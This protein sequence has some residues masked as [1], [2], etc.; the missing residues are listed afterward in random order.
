MADDTDDQVS[1][2]DTMIV[3]AEPKSSATVI[4]AIRQSRKAFETYNNLC[5]R[6]DALLSAKQQV[7]G[8]AS[9]GGWTDQE[10]DL[11]WA[12]LEILKP[13]IYA[14]PPNVVVSPR[15]KDSGQVNK[16]VSELLERVINSEFERGDIDQVML[17]MR[18]DLAVANRGVGW[19]TLDDDDDGKS[20]CIEHLDRADFLHEPARKWSEVGWV[21]RCAYMTKKQMAD[22]FR[23]KS[24]LAYQK[25]TF[26]ND[27]TDKDNGAA[28]DSMRAEVWELW[29]K[30]D[31][32]VYWVNESVDVF[33]DED[34]PHLQLDKGF[35]CP[36]PAYGSKQRRSLVPV[37]DY[38]RYEALLGQINE[39]TIKIYDLLEQVRMF[40]LIP[41]G[42]DVGNAIQAALNASDNSTFTLI[43]VPTAQ[44]GAAGAGGMAVWWPIE[45]VANTITG[46]IGA[47]Q[48]L[49][50][51]F[52]NLS[53]ISD[54]MRG[55]SD[56]QETLGAQRLKGQYGS[57]RIKDKCDELVR[58]AR[59][60]AAITGE[61]IC[62]NFDQ[63]TLLEISQMIIPTK[64]DINKQLKT[65]EDAAK[66][67]LK[68]VMDQAEQ[69]KAQL[70]Q[71]P[72]PEQ[73]QQAEQQFTQA[74]Q[75]IIGKYGPQIKQLQDTV[76]IDAVMEVIKDRRTRDMI[77]DIETDS[78]VMVDEMA[79]K[80]SRSEFLAAFSQA[81]AA[82]QPLLAA[83]EE[84][85]KLGGAMLK[86]ALQPFSANRELD[87]MI[88]DFVEKAPQLA[89]Q[90]QG[91]D[92]QKGMEE[93]NATIAQA[94]LQKAQAATARVQ[95]D[96]QLKQID[97]TRKM[98]ELQ[99]SAQKDQFNQQQETARFQKDLAEAQ[100]KINLM[101]AQTAQIL[102][103]IGLD[104]KKQELSQYETAADAN[105]KQVDTAIK[106]SGEARAHRDQQFSHAQQI[107]QQQIESQQPDTALQ[108]GGQ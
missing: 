35:P 72:T 2:S 41:G 61:I 51:D 65:L 102:S 74:Q 32:K 18:D 27:R 48:Q 108:Q 105:Q 95:A 98:N 69:M 14:K 77:I 37:P 36:R 91:N 26:T 87:Q 46:L 94:E 16:V 100:A 43:P 39:C 6:I 66:G 82:I 96:A 20:V 30:A 78:T 49:F 9:M 75:A 33:L 62:D 54:I 68:G 83:G 93:A 99:L 56:A 5:K 34:E 63:K 59:D 7:V 103:S 84:G 45:Q 31:D 28:D 71:Q 8:V 17:D 67:E 97:L 13:A 52:D 38:I 55:E 53:G 70:Q 1:P 4:E 80:A 50:S 73:Q 25:A 21:A 107:N 22:R 44:F 24:G 42:G 23:D 79:E 106:V 58:A 104:V 85:A 60:M 101:E 12:S 47:R 11:F 15:F 19:L 10:Y 40:G 3:K 92:S 29:S 76:T 57:V 88:D 81:T 64:A 86:F 89:A 90:Q